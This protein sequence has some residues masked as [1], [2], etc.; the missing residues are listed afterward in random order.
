MNYIVNYSLYM[1]PINAHHSFPQLHLRYTAPLIPKHYHCQQTFS[2]LA[3]QTCP[4]TTKI[5]PPLQQRSLYTFP[6]KLSF[7]LLYPVAIQDTW[8]KIQAL[9]VITIS[10]YIYSTLHP[11]F[12][13]FVNNFYPIQTNLRICLI[14]ETRSIESWANR[15]FFNKTHPSNSKLEVKPLGE[16]FFHHSINDMMHPIRGRTFKCTTSL[17]RTTKET[18]TVTFLGNIICIF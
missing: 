1:Y 17:Q 10:K 13:I 5:M 18:I 12:P 14:T 2:D 11:L 16:T 8:N 4:L 7:E 15:I 3:R 6:E 9:N